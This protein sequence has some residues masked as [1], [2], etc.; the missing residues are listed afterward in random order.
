[1][2]IL[3]PAFPSMNSCYNVNL[4]TKQV[5]QD[6]LKRAANIAQEMKKD[7]ER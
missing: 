4:T 3:T 6:E 2:P 7:I 1:M 5:L